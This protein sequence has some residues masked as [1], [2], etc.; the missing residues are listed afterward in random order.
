[1]VFVFGD[2]PIQIADFLLGLFYPGIKKAYLRVELALFGVGRKSATPNDYS[3]NQE[4][5]HEHGEPEYQHGY[6]IG[7]LLFLPMRFL[8]ISGGC[9]LW[10]MPGLF[11][12]DD[13]VEVIA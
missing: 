6:W 2:L 9:C 8:L 10:Q 13:F 11:L 12:S 4:G 5:Y 1:M 3:E 7:H